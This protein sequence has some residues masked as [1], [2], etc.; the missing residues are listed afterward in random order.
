[1]KKLFA[2]VISFAL[3]FVMIGCS[4]T[5]NTVMPDASETADLP[6]TSKLDDIP[7]S[8]GQLYAVAYLGYEEIEGLSF[9]AENYLDNENLPV[10][11]ISQGEYYLVI[12]RYTDMA[13]RLYRN[14]IETTE[15]I[16]V[17]EEAESR[18]FIIQCNV[19][20]IFSDATICLTSQTETVEFSPYISLADGN[21][22]AGDRGLDITASLNETQKANST[23]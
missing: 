20:D 11:Y 21:V 10:H 2:F 23:N 16:L 4:D 9:Y 3:L 5:S 1:M 15:R 18:P 8:D 12:P 14:D 17:Y 7:F 22:E 6:K 13:M 19:S